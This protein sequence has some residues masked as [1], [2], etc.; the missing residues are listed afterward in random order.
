M[1]YILGETVPSLPGA[2]HAV[3]AVWRSLQSTPG[4][5]ARGR[6]AG[7]FVLMAETQKMGK[8]NLKCIS[9]QLN[10]LDSHAVSLLF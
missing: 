10:P 7:H 2:V 6:P 5:W 3:P 8:F 4:A 1:L 9:S